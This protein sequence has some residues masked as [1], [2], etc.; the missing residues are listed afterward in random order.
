MP[1]VKTTVM[2]GHKSIAINLKN[3][4]FSSIVPYPMRVID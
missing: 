3:K 2:F 1:G 4:L